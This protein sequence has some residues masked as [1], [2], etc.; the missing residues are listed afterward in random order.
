MVLPG[1]CKADIKAFCKDVTAGDARLVS[2]LS[3]RLKAD[4]QGNTA[5]VQCSPC[6]GHMFLFMLAN[7]LLRVDSDLQDEQYQ[8][9]VLK[10]LQS[11]R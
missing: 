3:K 4:K 9:G 8:R 1:P 10:L 7:H 11:S 2:C 6:M 5:G